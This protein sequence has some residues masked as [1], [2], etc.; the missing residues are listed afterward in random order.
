MATKLEK[1]RARHEIALEKCDDIRKVAEAEERDFTPDEEKAFDSAMADA[2]AAK[3]EIASLEKRAERFAALDKELESARNVPQ[4]RPDAAASIQVGQ[5]RQSYDPNGGFRN[6]GDFLLSV[7]KFGKGYS[8]D[9]RLRPFQSA[10]GSDEQGEYSGSRGAFLLPVGLMPG[11]LSVPSQ[12]DPT[13][14]L[15]TRI[16]METASIKVNARTDKDHSDSVSGGL[17]VYR[18]AETQQAEASAMAMEQ[19]TLEA[20]SLMGVAYITEE[21]IQDSPIS[22]IGLLE[23]GFRDEFTSKELEEK[24]TGTGVG[25]FS[26]VLGAD[27][28]VTVDT[29]GATADAITYEQ[30]LEMRA[31]CWGYGSAAWMANHSCLVQLGLIADAAD[32]NI[33]V[34]DARADVPDTLLGRPLYVTEYLP[35]LGDAGDLLLGNWSQYLYAE[36]Q[37]LETGES[38]HV[39]F[40]ENERTIKV[41]K[42]NAGAPWWRSVLT[43][44]N[45]PTL[46]PFVV[47]DDRA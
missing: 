43:P 12:A 44:K 34:T 25:Q 30:V 19:I 1:A 7:V 27:C 16:M 41:S 9:A 24:L 38:V 37:G 11:L 6:A 4:A 8:L 31:R 10:A 28:L 39:R 46:S 42:R 5:D 17:R 35:E 18:R 15:V 47:L 21:L 26:G 40:L 13:A 14:D 20:D 32:R 29:S 22:V 23:A 3:S 45:G 36:R 33:L 2:E